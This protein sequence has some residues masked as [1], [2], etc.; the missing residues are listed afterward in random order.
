M[1][2]SGNK[3]VYPYQGP[4]VIG[5]V[6]KKVIGG[7]PTSFY[8]LALLDGSG[9]ELFIPVDKISG[10]GIR[11]LMARSEIPKLLGLLRKPAVTPTNWKQRAIDN[12][13]LLTSGSAFDLAEVVE[14]LTE[15]NEARA[16]SPRDRQ[17]LDRARRILI[18]EI[19]EV[20]GE[21]KGAAEEQVDQALSV[22][23]KHAATDRK[24]GSEPAIMM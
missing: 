5:A 17:T 16:L 11:Q 24:K 22:R 2:K 8:H 1:L 9:G 21:T 18:C 23:K 7:R 6:V 12:F 3:V 14:S 15:L 20:T 4:C 10:V 19:S 13:K